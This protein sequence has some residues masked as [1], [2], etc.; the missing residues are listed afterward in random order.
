M[1]ISKN[2]ELIAAPFTPMHKDGSLNSGMIKKY[3]LKL[4][5]DNVSGVFVCGTTG[6]GLLM[7]LDERKEI[8][9]AWINEQTDNFKVI[10][11]V[12]T[13]SSDQSCELAAHAQSC[14]AFATSAMG[15]LFLPPDN[16]GRLLDFCEKIASCAPDIPFYYYHIPSVT[17]LNLPMDIFLE[18]GQ[19][20]IPNLKGIKYSNNNFA[21]LLKCI[22]LENGKWDIFF[23]CDDQLLAGLACGVRGAV[24][25]TY[26]YMAH[27]YHKLIEDFEKGDFDAA[28]KKQESSIDLINILIKYGGA[29]VAGKVLMRLIGLNCGPCR[30]PLRKFDFFLYDKFILEIDKTGIFPKLV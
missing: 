14:G 27:L 20:K 26:N 24:G 8:A 2:S 22:L 9:E 5:N 30:L 17:H 7:T 25:S 1:N 13:T 23:G 16:T 15:P 21:E 6:E 12:G 4:K 3:A 11:H 28:R 10:V 29:I 18:E 19:G